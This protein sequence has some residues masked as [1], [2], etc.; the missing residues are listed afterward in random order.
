MVDPLKVIEERIQRLRAK[1]EKHEKALESARCELSDMETALRVLS[2]VMG[3][4]TPNTGMATYAS[5]ANRQRDIL[6]F[7]SE[8]AE[9]SQAPVGIFNAYKV[10]AV[11]DINIDTF[12]TTIWRMRD[13]WFDLGGV[14]WCVRSANGAYWKEKNN[15]TPGAAT[16]GV[17]KEFGREAESEDSSVAQ[18]RAANPESVGS[19][20]TAS[21]PQFKS[22][23][24]ADLDD[25]VPF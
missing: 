14:Q 16:P 5:V 12:R 6:A 3:E 8:G 13:K 1:V 19:N 2:G 7:L 18:H 11:G 4:S 9:N 24:D 22:A 10:S 17:S 20:P 23:F 15:E 25:D 21:V